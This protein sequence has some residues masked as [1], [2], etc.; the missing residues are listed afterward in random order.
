MP[1]RGACF[2]GRGVGRTVQLNTPFKPS[3]PI[4]RKSCVL[5]I[6]H[7][8]DDLF[9][10]NLVCKALSSAGYPVTSCSKLEEAIECLSLNEFSVAIVDLQ[11]DV[12]S[13]IELVREIVR[14]DL[15]TKV[16]I[17]TANASVQS[18][19]EGIDLRVFAYVDKSAGLDQL[20]THTARANAAYHKDSLSVAQKEIQLQIRLLD[21]LQE[22]VIATDRNL[23]VIYGNQAAGVLLSK[24]KGEL[25]AE[26]ASNWFHFVVGGLSKDPRWLETD[27]KHFDWNGPWSQ[28]AYLVDRVRSSDTYDFVRNGDPQ[29][30]FRLSVSPIP[31]LSDNISG[32]I[33]LF[34][35]ITQE[36]KVEK[37][38]Q[39]AIQIANH[40]QRVAT[41][42]QMATIL[43]HEVN[44]PLSAIG[45]YVGGLL[46]AC[47]AND[48]EAELP[49]ILNL[50]LDQSLRA[51]KITRQ[52]RSYV[53]KDDFHHQPLRINETIEHAIQLVEVA[54]RS[55]RVE[56][57]VCLESE[58]AVVQ[59]NEILLSQVF[60][61]LL[62]NAFEAIELAA[63]S[64]RKVIVK[65]WRSDFDVLIEIDDHGPGVSPEKLD[66][67]FKAYKSTK[68]GGLGL[69]LVI[70]Y[71]IIS[72][73]HGSIVAKN[74]EPSGLSFRITLPLAER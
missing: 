58:S 22:G 68:P 48:P 5:N 38:L 74:R 1:A 36:K 53:T 59:G 16:V 63:A 37:Q 27:L 13:G 7:L 23:N 3:L 54:A 56:I 52:L 69:G 44:Q 40:A 46:L 62:I 17:H 45:N 64:N 28:E 26:N 49:R 11:L 10:R 8:E 67:L 19:L 31:G 72:Q 18:A 73:H 25:L 24:P 35:D 70:S 32:Y 66:S 41:L 33:L 14:R 12:G 60:V 71:L 6:L 2:T 50:I 61:N 21:S 34:T 51:G 57:E 42:G 4:L 43:A 29:K 9:Q 15:Q 30:M 55:Y 20:T 39:D 65:S 47:D